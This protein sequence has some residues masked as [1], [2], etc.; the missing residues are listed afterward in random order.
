MMKSQKKIE[1]M[2]VINFRQNMFEILNKI[3]YENHEII[4]TRY[5][6]DIAKVINLEENKKG[7]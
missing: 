5:G 4:L 7:G 1:R 3:K 6:K 2:A